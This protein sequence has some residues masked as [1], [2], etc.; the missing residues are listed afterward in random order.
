MTYLFF[1]GRAGRRGSMK[2]AVQEIVKDIVTAVNK[3]HDDQVVTYVGMIFVKNGE[4][5]LSYDPAT[6]RTLIG[7]HAAYG[8]ENT[9]TLLRFVATHV[10]TPP[11]ATRPTTPPGAPNPG[12]MAC[13]CLHF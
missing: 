8:P 12:G 9:R 3:M 1:P 2:G 13:R 10:D 6:L 4:K 7:V 5:L 11:A